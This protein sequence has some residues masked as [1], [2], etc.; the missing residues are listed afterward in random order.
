[1]GVFLV[2]C[3]LL[4][5]A[6]QHNGVVQ[7][8]AQLVHAGIQI[9]RYL[10]VKMRIECVHIVVHGIVLVELIGFGIQISLAAHEIVFIVLHFVPEAVLA[11]IAAV[12]TVGT[13]QK[14]FGSAKARLLHAGGKIQRSVAVREGDAHRVGRRILAERRRDIG[15][16][17][18]LIQRKIAVLQLPAL[19]GLA[20]V[21]LV[22]RGM[23]D[24]TAFLQ[25]SGHR[26]RACALGHRNG[27][28]GAF[29]GVAAVNFAQHTGGCSG[30]HCHHGHHCQQ[31]G[32]ALGK[33]AF[34][35]A[36]VCNVF[37]L[38]IH[39]FPSFLL[40]GQR[41]RGCWRQCLS[42][43]AS[44]AYSTRKYQKAGPKT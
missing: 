15:I 6:G 1:M 39:D 22:E 37:I 20:N 3:F 35:L 16:A 19:A 4:H 25:Q 30:G 2:A 34:F 12:L 43:P 27:D 5:K 42:Y 21:Q 41:R 31:H 38:L 26:A 13:G 14:L 7:A 29:I 9:I 28:L 23:A 36:A 33:A 18:A 40:L 11:E 8:H 17:F 32:A 44:S 24:H 10:A